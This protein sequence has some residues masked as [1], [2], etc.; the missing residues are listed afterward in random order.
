[1]E[2]LPSGTPFD[3]GASNR[4]HMNID[5]SPRKPGEKV[6]YTGPHLCVTCADAGRITSRPLRA[7]DP[8][9]SC[10]HCGPRARWEP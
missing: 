5:I 6:L 4:D 3:S 2:T 9:P 7:G 8:A 1:M 10:E